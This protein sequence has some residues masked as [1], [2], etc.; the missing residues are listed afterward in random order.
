MESYDIMYACNV[1]DTNIEKCSSHVND[2]IDRWGSKVS[3]INADASTAFTGSM[4]SSKVRA[5]MHC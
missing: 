2:M 5:D 1:V 3:S 4:L